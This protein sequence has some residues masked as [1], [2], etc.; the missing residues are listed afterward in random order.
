MQLI[1]DVDLLRGILPGRWTI[2]ASNFPMWTDGSRRQPTFEYGLAREQPLVLTDVVSYVDAEGKAKSI[3]GRDTWR[4][5][6]FSWRGAGI[7]A[8]LRSL[9]AVAMVE[10]DVMA[11][12]FEKS[13]ATPAGVD[14]VVR[15]GVDASGLRKAVA[16]NPAHYGITIEEFASLTWLDHVPVD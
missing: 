10:Q 12:R 8:P 1:Q 3:K 11:I 5:H 14:I 4:G 7:L 2:H 13:L 16:A 15:E 9:W 6:H